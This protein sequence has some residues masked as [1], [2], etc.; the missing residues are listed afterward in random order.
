MPSFFKTPLH[1]SEATALSFGPDAVAAGSITRFRKP[2]PA[3]HWWLLGLVL[4]GLLLL[5]PAPHWRTA[6]PS[7][8]PALRLAIL[9]EPKQNKRHTATVV[10]STEKSPGA[11][12]RSSDTPQP[13]P[14][15]STIAHTGQRAEM[16][17]PVSKPTVQKRQ[18]PTRPAVKPSIPSSTASPHVSPSQLA[19]ILAQTTDFDTEVS[20]PAE[21]QAR[22]SRLPSYHAPELLARD[23]SGPTPGLDMTAD[24]PTQEIEFYDFGW[25]GSAERLFE[26][27]VP[28]KTYVTRYGTRITCMQL[29]LMRVC[30]WGASELNLSNDEQ[31]RLDELY[32]ALH[33]RPLW[34]EPLSPAAHPAKAA[35]ADPFPPAA[36]QGFPPKAIDI[37][38][39]RIFPLPA[40][41]E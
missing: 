18:A 21:F 11:K 36:P 37:P 34:T 33:N 17:R 19:A 29:A 6:G 13:K 15:T 41:P 14:T 39:Q 23:W 27:L 38:S 28:T 8:A 5:L 35:G 30:A 20:V 25:Q 4:T 32:S 1:H 7:T 3:F 24:V 40:K 2:V 9:S 12:E 22:Q 16:K 10:Q 26:K 31:Q